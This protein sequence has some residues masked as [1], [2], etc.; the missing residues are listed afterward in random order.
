MKSFTPLWGVSAC[1][2]GHLLK[3]LELL[4]DYSVKEKSCLVEL[5]WDVH[6]HALPIKLYMLLVILCPAQH[7]C[8]LKNQ[9][10]SYPL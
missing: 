1:T 2:K 7:L 5:S 4:F 3:S 8:I 6:L 9:N 10:Y